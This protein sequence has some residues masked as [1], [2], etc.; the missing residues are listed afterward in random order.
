MA[1]M[2]YKNIFFFRHIND[3]GGIETFFWELAQKYHNW[4]ITI[5]YSTGNAAQIRRLRQYVRVIQYTNQHIECEKAFF[6]YNLDIIDNVDADEYIQIA[7]GD[8]K[9]MGIKPNDHPR[10]DRYLGVSKQVCSTYEEV[11]GHKTELTYNPFIKPKPRKIL[12]LISA[13]RLTF[14]K[15]GKRMEKLFEALEN[16]HIP[17]IWT[18][19]TTDKP[20]MKSPNVIYRAPT[21]SITDYMANN[22]YLVQLSDNEGY[23]YSAIEALSVGTQLIVTDCPVFRELGVNEDNAFILPF[24]MSYIPVQ[25]MY[26]RACRPGFREFEYNPPEDRWA[27]ILVPGESTYEAEKEQD[28][29]VKVKNKYYDVEEAQ[30]MKPGDIFITNKARA[31]V[32]VNAGMADIEEG[33]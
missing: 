4:D 19:F 30:M 24:D 15:G 26:D 6:N 22:D 25:E 17:Y 10:L 14:E 12:N 8:Y 3:I 9:S 1:K 11:T 13:T 33:V 31:D 2:K 23:C 16:A 21:L 18:I 32:L 28:V 27:E 20:R 29:V 7:H 5:F